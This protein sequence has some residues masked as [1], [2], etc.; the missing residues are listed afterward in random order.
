MIVELV[1]LAAVGGVAYLVG[2]AKGKA[3]LAALKVDA[4]SLEAS[5]VSGL[6]VVEAKVKAEALALIAKVKAL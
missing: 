1:V 2:T 5:V 4:A 3:D 6:F